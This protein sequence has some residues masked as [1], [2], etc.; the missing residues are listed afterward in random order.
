MTTTDDDYDNVRQRRRRRRMTTTTTTTTHDDGRLRQR[1]TMED[2]DHNHYD[3]RRTTTTTYDNHNHYDARRKTTTAAVTSIWWLFFHMNLG[4]PVPTGSS[5]VFSTY[6]RRESLEIEERDFYE[7][8]VLRTNHASVSKNWRQ[9]KALTLTSGLAS[10]FLHLPQD[11]WQKGTDSFT[12]S[13]QQKYQRQPTSQYV[14]K[15]KYI[16]K[17]TTTQANWH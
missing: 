1:T 5:R 3:A 8:T 14:T 11:Y 12:P 7:L 9:H 4:Q 16:Q 10:S 15:M 17:L 6:S 13:F 2:D